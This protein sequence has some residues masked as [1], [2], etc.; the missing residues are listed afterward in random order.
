LQLLDRADK[1]GGKCY[2]ATY[3]LSGHDLIKHLT[4]LGK[5]K[6]HLVLSNAAKI[7]RMAVATATAP[8]PTR[9]ASFIRSVS[10]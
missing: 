8:I 2:C 10:M 9:G 4:A 3:E 7:P 5:K 1:D 6:L